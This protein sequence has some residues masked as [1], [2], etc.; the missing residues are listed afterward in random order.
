MS[1]SA[2]DVRWLRMAARLALRGHGGAEPNPMVGAVI[3]SPAGH[4]VGSGY[5]RK[6]GQAHAEINALRQAGAAARGATLFC[7]L[8]PCSHVGRTAA[9]TDAIVGAGIARVVVARRDPNPIAADGF[10][11]LRAAGIDVA[12]N[13]LSELAVS[14]SDPFVH[15]LRSGLP[16]VTAKWAQTLEGGIATGR[17]GDP[18]ISSPRSRR[19]VHRERGRVDAIITGIGTVKC[20]DPLLTARDVRVR[21]T[22]TRLVIDPRLEI[23]PSARLVQTAR[24]VPTIVAT[25]GRS[26][27]ANAVHAAMLENAGAELWAMPEKSG[28]LDLASV[29]RQLASGR[30]ATHV[31]V[32]AGAGL[33]KRLFKQRLVNEAWVFIAR[34]G[35]LG[36]GTEAMV[37]PSMATLCGTGQLDLWQLRCRDDDLIARFRVRY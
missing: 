4:V 27:E 22:A 35:G 16:W 8:E 13:E 15:R 7:T 11:K 1:H 18:W 24:R 31:L 20:D 28:E 14:V 37:L 19:L 23:A 9:C 5:H 32:E 34:R 36:G 30:D 2:N 10:A 3:V 17:T 29:M 25:I 12:V 26:I 6:C 33:L 21:R